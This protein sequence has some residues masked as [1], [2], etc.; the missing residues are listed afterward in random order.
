MN[1]I[2]QHFKA[3]DKTDRDYII[4]RLCVIHAAKEKNPSNKP[5]EPTTRAAAD[6]TVINKKRG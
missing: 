6:H 5:T 1:W 2:I 3:L 4:T